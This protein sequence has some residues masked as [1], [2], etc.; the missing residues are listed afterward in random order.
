MRND[1]LAWFGSLAL[2][3]NLVQ[4]APEA[5]A[6]YTPPAP[7]GTPGEPVPA[8]YP[9]PD[10]FEQIPPE[11]RLALERGRISRILREGRFASDQ[12]RQAF[13]AYFQQYFFPSWTVP[14]N[15]IKLVGRWRADLARLLS[16]GP[17]ATNEPH[18]R[19]NQLTAEFLG[20]RLAEGNFHPV[21]RY[22][23]ITTI[24][25]LNAVEGANPVPWG[26]A[27]PILL[28]A[29]T[30]ET[31]IDAVKVAALLGLRRH[32]SL[33]GPQNADDRSKVIAAAVELAQQSAL[34]EGREPD[35]H[36]WM[37]GVAASLLGA[38]R[39]P[40]QNGEV[41]QALV[42]LLS[43]D[44]ASLDARREAAEALG[45]LNYGG[46]GAPD[47]PAAVQALGQYVLAAVAVEE[48]SMPSRR[49]LKSR[50]LAAQ[51]GI[52]GLGAAAGQLGQGV[53][54]QIQDM[55]VR[56]ETLS[57][58]EG[59]VIAITEPRAKLLQLLQTN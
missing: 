25:E 44:T 37:R 32:A 21:V 7:I 20:Q 1:I 13:D 16:S 41:A 15:R 48:G 10:S 11:K 23:A 6:Q 22:N 27:V 9:P 26:P 8:P 58:D 45:R 52:A 49:R 54:A 30:S 40:G 12:E 2:L 38:M 47:A 55:L 31:Q 43:D 24:G 28:G 4:P 57:Q 42:A 29:L 46:G 3:A 14:E 5:L 18:E 50:L 34:P 19:L 17:R 35:A 53:A 51:T 33:G 36:D 59:L 56:M 39:N